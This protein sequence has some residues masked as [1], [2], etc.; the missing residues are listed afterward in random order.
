MRHRLSAVVLATVFAFL[1]L[2]APAW[3]QSR[4]NPPAPYPIPPPNAGT[5]TTCCSGYTVTMRHGW[6]AEF[7]EVRRTYDYNW[8]EAW[9]VVTITATPNAPAG[10]TYAVRVP[11]RAIDMLVWD[12]AGGTST[13]RG[14]T[15]R[16]GTIQ[17]ID[18]RG[19]PSMA[20]NAIGGAFPGGGFLSVVHAGHLPAVFRVAVQNADD[21]KWFFYTLH[22]SDIR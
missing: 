21:G 22:S 17:P 7:P 14:G 19:F 4:P 13:V 12:P 2:A 16:P 11:G 8:P 1:V 5:Q 20:T 3:A 10:N 18:A 15:Y 9:P 6:P